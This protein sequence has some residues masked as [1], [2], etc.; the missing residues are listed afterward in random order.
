[1]LQARFLREA[2]A[3]LRVDRLARP[4]AVLPGV[5]AAA[6]TGHDVVDAA[7]VGLQHRAGVLAAIAIAL[8]NSLRAELRTTLR[9]ARKVRQ[10]DN[11]RQAN[12]PAHG[13]H[14]LI[15]VANGQTNPFS[16]RHGTNLLFADDL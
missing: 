3:L 7:F 12:R 13:V 2:I 14:R 6:R 4:D 10:H 16:P 11:G 5:A 8:A 15:F 9:H 1:E